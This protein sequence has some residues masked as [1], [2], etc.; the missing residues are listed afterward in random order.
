[1]RIKNIEENNRKEQENVRTQHQ[2]KI[3]QMNTEMQSR[4]NQLEKEKVQLMEQRTRTIELEK[5]KMSYIYKLEFFI[6]L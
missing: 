6:N 3:N 2:K 1:M 4:I 5:S